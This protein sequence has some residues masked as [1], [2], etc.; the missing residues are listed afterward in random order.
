M[1]FGVAAPATSVTPFNVKV[2]DPAPP[3]IPLPVVVIFSRP[4]L[5]FKVPEDLKPAPRSMAGPLSLA[6]TALVSSRLPIVKVPVAVP[7]PAP[8]LVPTIRTGP[9]PRMSR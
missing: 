7:V 9:L 4:L 8:E 5:R 2:L 3:V 1:K 6:V